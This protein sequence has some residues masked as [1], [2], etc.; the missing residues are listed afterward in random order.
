MLCQVEACRSASDCL[1]NTRQAGIARLRTSD[2]CSGRGRT[3][4]LSTRRVRAS[5][6]SSSIDLDGGPTCLGGLCELM[7]ALVRSNTSS[8]E[9]AGFPTPAAC[10][11]QKDVFP[12][13]QLLVIL[14]MAS[15]QVPRSR[16]LRDSIVWG[17]GKPSSGPDPTSRAE[18]PVLGLLLPK[19][20]PKLPLDRS[21]GLY[22]LRAPCS[23][24]T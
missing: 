13:L 23:L 18:N 12:Q 4:W 10:V 11:E 1:G 7:R 8:F 22:A 19:S 17:E 15:G 24:I 16:L 20:V 2:I 21:A 5:A 14:L 9:I 6:Q 3:A